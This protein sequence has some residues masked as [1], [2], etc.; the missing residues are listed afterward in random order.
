[1]CPLPVSIGTD[2]C[3]QPGTDFHQNPSGPVQA[4]AVRAGAP[5][6]LAGRILDQLGVAGR[7]QA[8]RQLGILRELGVVGAA[9]DVELH[10]VPVG[11]WRLAVPAEPGVPGD[12]ARR[13]RRRGKALGQAG[14]DG[15]PDRRPVE[16]IR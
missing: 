16:R 4:G 10:R 12:P 9:H 7:Q 6:R 5:E 3:T 8:G 11:A 14:M 1:M 13:G 2:L 15:C